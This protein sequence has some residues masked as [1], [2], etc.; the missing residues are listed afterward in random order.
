MNYY[1]AQMKWCERTQSICIGKNKIKV[2]RAAL[3]MLKDE[4]GTGPVSRGAALCSEPIVGDD[5]E[6]VLIPV[7]E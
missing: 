6:I 5:V 1:L 3:K 7:I 4:H 2:K